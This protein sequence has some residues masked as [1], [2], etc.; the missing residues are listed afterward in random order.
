MNMGHIQIVILRAKSESARAI[1]LVMSAGPKNERRIS[2]PRLRIKTH[3]SCTIYDVYGGDC[4]CNLVTDHSSLTYLRG[5]S[6]ICYRRISCERNTLFD[7]VSSVIVNVRSDIEIVSLNMR[8]RLMARS[9]AYRMTWLLL[10]YEK[11][12]NLQQTRLK[13]YR[14]PIYFAVDTG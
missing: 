4:L 11:L 12:C 5:W 7:I 9:T 1:K 14:L 3:P 8:E 6:Y 10:E 2:S 13:C